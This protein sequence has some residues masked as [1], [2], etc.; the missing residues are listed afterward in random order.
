MSCT[1]PGNVDKP[2][3]FP[4]VTSGYPTEAV[5]FDLAYPVNLEDGMSE[6]FRVQGVQLTVFEVTAPLELR[7]KGSSQQAQASV[8]SVLS[9]SSA[10]R[11]GRA[12]LHDFVG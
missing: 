1:I 12:L 6:R 3:Q 8:D 4:G 7:M 11:S 10:A 5:R 9:L 2:D